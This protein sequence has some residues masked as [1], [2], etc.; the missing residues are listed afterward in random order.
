MYSFIYFWL[1]WVCIAVLAFS[2]C[3]KQR[4]F[5]PGVQA[6]YCSDLSCGVW[7]PGRVGSVVVAP[8]HWG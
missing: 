4:L 1:R 8:P 5:S 7:A 2:S 6:S 3:G